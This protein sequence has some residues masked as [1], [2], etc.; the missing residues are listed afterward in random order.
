MKWLRA[1]RKILTGRWCCRCGWFKHLFDKPFDL[2]EHLQLMAQQIADSIDQ[3]IFDDL[4][5]KYG[6]TNDEAV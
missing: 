1:V 5:E 6:R 3:D 2:D 4:R